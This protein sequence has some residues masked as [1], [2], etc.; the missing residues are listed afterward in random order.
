MTLNPLSMTVKDNHYTVPPLIGHGLPQV[1]EYVYLSP[2]HAG[3]G[4]PRQGGVGGNW[5]QVIG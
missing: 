4:R 5:I 2:C 1:M 3:E